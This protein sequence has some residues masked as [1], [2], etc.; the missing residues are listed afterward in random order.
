MR[1][2]YEVIRDEADLRIVQK[3]VHYLE[4]LQY[5]QAEDA[6]SIG[7]QRIMECGRKI[8]SYTPSSVGACVA[9]LR[10]VKILVHVPEDLIRKGEETLRFLLPLCYRVR[11]KQRKW[12]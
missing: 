8:L 6:Y 11:V 2:I 1:Q 7:K 9:G 10:A 3:L 4:C 12:I 5:W